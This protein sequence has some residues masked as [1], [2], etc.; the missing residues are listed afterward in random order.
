VF[1]GVGAGRM[2]ALTDARGWVTA[3]AIIRRGANAV[4]VWDTTGF[5][6]SAA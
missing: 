3:L 4:G 5:G 1:D 6:A 2:A